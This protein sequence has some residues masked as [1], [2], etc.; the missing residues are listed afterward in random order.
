MPGSTP[1]Q[2]PAKTEE[3]KIEV[4]LLS[5]VWIEDKDHEESVEGIRRLRTNIPEL[6]EDGGPMID[7]KTKS[8]ITKTVNVT[9][10]L[11]VAKKLIAEGKA[12]RADP[13]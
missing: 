4:T 2:E 3:R 8:I 6:R 7:P 13:L 5:D 12:E 1:A 11:S 10:P 9:L